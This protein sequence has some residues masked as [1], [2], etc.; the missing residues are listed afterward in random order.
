MRRFISFTA[1]VLAAGLVSGVLAAPAASAQQSIN[2]FAGGFA[3]PGFD[4]R[5]ATDVVRNNLGF[6]DFNI[7]DFNSPTFGGEYLVG[8]GNNV[9]A[10]LG[11]GFQTRTV[12]T[13]YRDFV[14]SDGS[15]IEQ[16][17]KLRVIPFTATVRLLPL[18]SRNSFVPY[19]GAGVG[20]FRW[21]Y[22]ESGQFIAT[23]N[24]IFN[25]S[26]VGSGSATGPV[27]L[28]GVRVPM[29]SGGFGGEIRYQSAKGNLPTDQGFQGTT[30][31]LGGISYL[32][33][34][35]FRF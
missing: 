20:V 6:L 27:V 26:F 15:E 34:V 11:I 28:G 2:L 32:F 7:S 12:P 1:G 18:G 14:N 3:A 17:L 9:E 33:M 23:D 21:R 19:I 24:S 5:P 10:G 30:I 35:N 22:S 4:S 29:G 8:L 25:D 13:V 16:D 31:D